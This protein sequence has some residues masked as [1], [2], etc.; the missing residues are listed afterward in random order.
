MS[1]LYQ[2]PFLRATASRQ[3]DELGHKFKQ[4]LMTCFFLRFHMMLILIGVALSGVIAN[5]LLLYFG[6]TSMPV[7]YPVAVIFSYAVFFLLIRIWLCY[8]SEASE[9]HAWDIDITDIA[10]VAEVAD[11]GR[12]IHGATRGRSGRWGLDFDLPD[13]D[14]DEATILVV[15]AL[16]LL[17]IFGV[18]AY[19]VYEAPAILAE[20]AFQAVLASSLVKASNRMDTPGWMG[21]LVKTTWAPFVVVLVMAAGLGWIAHLYCPEA[22]KLTELFNR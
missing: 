19:L 13:F 11:V 21:S 16:L 14:V 5:K 12:P 9:T 20:A 2:Q 7:R 10:D 6:V 17:A 8:M 1:H 18:G 4:S 15:F 3:P 22:T